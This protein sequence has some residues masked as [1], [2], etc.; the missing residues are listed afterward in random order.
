MKTGVSFRGRAVRDA[1]AAAADAYP[2]PDAIAIRMSPAQR[3]RFDAKRSFFRG[4]HF[5]SLAAKTDTKARVQF[6]YP[7][8][9]TKPLQ[10]DA[11]NNRDGHERVV[12]ASDAE[13]S[14][15]LA[16]KVRFRGV[17][18]LRDCARRK[19]MKVN[20]RGRGRFRLAPGSAGDE[21]LLIS[22][23]YDDRYVVRAR[24]PLAK[25]LGAFRTPRPSQADRKSARR[26]SRR[27]RDDAATTRCCFT[28]KNTR[29]RGEG[30]PR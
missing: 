25:R 28:K 8:E 16:A 30:W 1:A 23:C 14:T 19:S 26:P 10:K 5:A 17:S 6:V 9:K 7:S 12:R 4:S 22:M 3:A 20:L 18:S 2:Y 15:P 24:V 13:A 11:F 21:F 29:S 27:R